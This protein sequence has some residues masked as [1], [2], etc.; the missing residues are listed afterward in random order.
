M[1]PWYSMYVS[2]FM[3]LRMLRMPRVLTGRMHPKGAW[4]PLVSRQY[5]ERLILLVPRIQPTSWYWLSEEV[6]LCF[7]PR[8][9]HEFT[10]FGLMHPCQNSAN[11]RGRCFQGDMVDLYWRGKLSYASP[12]AK[13]L[14]VST[15]MKEW[16]FEDNL[17]VSNISR[18]SK[19]PLE[20]DSR[21][22]FQIFFIFIPTWGRFPFWLTFFKWVEI[23]T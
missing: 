22:W 8:H 7:Y 5:F 18:P 2:N 15:S 11:S 20:K 16:K 13:N 9:V 4:S 12:T 1:I 3:P 6:N 23:T 14:G 17:G 21:W 10:W 19:N